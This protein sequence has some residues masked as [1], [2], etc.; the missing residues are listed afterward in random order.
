[1]SAWIAAAL[2]AGTLGLA[3]TEAAGVAG[4]AYAVIFALAL[5]PG[6]PIGFRLF[7]RRHAGGWIAGGALGY[8]LTSVGLWAAIALGVPGAAGFVVAWIVAA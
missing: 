3:I 4:L 8:F 7:G 1:M 5:V 6:L 2:L